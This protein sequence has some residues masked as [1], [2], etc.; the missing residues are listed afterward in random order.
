M[1]GALAH[2]GLSPFLGAAPQLQGHPEDYGRDIFSIR[3][4]CLRDILL[5]LPPPIGLKGM[6][7]SRSDANKLCF[8]LRLTPVNGRIGL[9]ELLEVLLR[10]RLTASAL[11]QSTAPPTP[12][13]S[14]TGVLSSP[15]QLPPLAKEPLGLWSGD[16]ATSMALDT[17]KEH[18]HERKNAEAINRRMQS[19]RLNQVMKRAKSRKPQQHTLGVPE[20][21]WQSVTSG[22]FFPI[23][24]LKQRWDALMM[25]L[26]LYTVVVVP[27]RV[28]FDDPA[29][30]R[31]WVFEVFVTLAFLSDLVATFN[32]AFLDGERWNVMRSQIAGRYLHGWFWVDLPASVP[33]ELIMLFIPEGSGTDTSKL[34][35]LRG[36]RLVRLVRLL[37]LLKLDEYIPT[38]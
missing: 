11:D 26:I 16:S 29:V 24:P 30:G 23:G 8:Q 5:R 15:L 36:L 2:L 25:F 37:K 19:R 20:H 35:M 33:V 31:W 28:G 32:T 21:A 7:A 9:Q 6:V 18:I 10:S 14:S 12:S 38:L 1:P 22:V 27:Y 34:K 13:T 17:L 3:M 4:A